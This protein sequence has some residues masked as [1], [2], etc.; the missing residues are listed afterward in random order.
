MQK[1]RADKSLGLT[2]DDFDKPEGGVPVQL[3]CEQWQQDQK[4]DIFGGDEEDEFSMD[5]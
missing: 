3:D 5:Y 2:W 1:C 4:N